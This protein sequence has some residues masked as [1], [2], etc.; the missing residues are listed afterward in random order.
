MLAIF[1]VL[2]RKLREFGPLVADRTEESMLRS[3]ATAIRGAPEQMMS[4]YPEDFD[5]YRIGSF[6][7]ETGVMTSDGPVLVSR[8]AAVLEQIPDPRKDARQLD[9]VDE[10]SGRG[11]AGL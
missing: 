11:P 9:V 1:S 3:L 10:L 4:K 5:L 6:D 2:D 8:V 7:P